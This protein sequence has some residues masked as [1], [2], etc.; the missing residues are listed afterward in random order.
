M[1]VPD[2]AHASDDERAETLDAVAEELYG[3]LPDEFVG[4]RDAAVEEARERGDRE[5]ARAIARLRRPTR[6]AWL[7]NLL[8]RQRS[9]QLEG[10]LGLAGG[11]AEAQ[12]T[13]D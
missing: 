5:L 9:A 1:R 10:L 12:R 6:A 7:A 8:A 11:L 13:L 2:E 4:G 3:L